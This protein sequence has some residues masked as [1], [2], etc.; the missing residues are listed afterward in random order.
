MGRKKQP[1]AAK[2]LPKVAAAKNKTKPKKAVVVEQPEEPVDFEDVKTFI[3]AQDSRGLDDGGEADSLM[4]MVRACS[5]SSHANT[6]GAK[7]RGS[8]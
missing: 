6:D 4:D 3:N 1:K 2:K 8:R 5:F 7:G